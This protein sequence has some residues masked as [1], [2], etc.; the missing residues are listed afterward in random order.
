M[1][2]ILEQPV[3]VGIAGGLFTLLLAYLAIQ[4]PPQHRKKVFAAAGVVVVITVLLIILGSSVQTETEKV[5]RMLFQTARDVESNDVERMLRHIH[6]QAKDIRTRAANEMRQYKFDSIDIKPN[7]EIT[8]DENQ[9]PA[10]AVRNS[11]WLPVEVFVTATSA[12]VCRC[13]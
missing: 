5:R 2:V 8:I 3:Y 11:T 12:I 1:N 9:T 7:L 10:L 13:S 4:C 6:P